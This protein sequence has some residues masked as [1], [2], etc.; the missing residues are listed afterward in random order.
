MM[1]RITTDICVIGGGSG[2]LSLAAG[3]AQAQRLALVL[4]SRDGL[5]GHGSGLGDG[6][7]RQL[8]AQQ[9]FVVRDGIVRV[10]VERPAWKAEVLLEQGSS[11]DPPKECGAHQGSPSWPGGAINML[12][13]ISIS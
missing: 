1:Q 6:D 10:R 8:E 11:S 7:R 2:G 3:A 13:C 4:E 5:V 9:R 12:G